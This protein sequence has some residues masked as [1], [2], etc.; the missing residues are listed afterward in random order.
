MRRARIPGNQRQSR[1]GVQGSV[2]LVEEVVAVML[3]GDEAG[4]YSSFR[5]SK[6]GLGSALG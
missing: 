6:G 4:G 1:G 2:R 3:E 5:G